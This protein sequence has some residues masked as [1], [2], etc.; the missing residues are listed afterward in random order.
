MTNVPSPSRATR[1]SRLMKSS[2]MPSPT[3]TEATPGAVARLSSTVRTNSRCSSVVFAIAGQGDARGVE[4]SRRE[5]DVGK[6]RDSCLIEIDA[7]DHEERHR[8]SGL[9]GRGE[10]LE[11]A[12]AL[13]AAGG[14]VLQRGDDGRAAE[15]QRGQRAEHDA[16]HQAEPDALQHEPGVGLEQ[17]ERRAPH[18]EQPGDHDRAAE[19]DGGREGATE[20][21]HHQ[22]LAQVVAHQAPAPRAHRGPHRQLALPHRAAHQHHAGDVQP[23]DEQHGGGQA[24]QHQPRG[25]E[26][27][28]HARPGGEVGLDAAGLVLI[29]GWITRR[30][31]RHAACTRASA[32]ATVVPS[33]SRTMA[34]THPH[35]G[36]D[37]HPRW[38]R[39]ADDATAAAR[40]GSSP[41]SDC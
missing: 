35:R 36:A 4:A 7:A 25:R 22:R 1:T 9:R 34:C 13:A 29:R 8:K 38:Q 39:A 3:L 27:R 26:L 41:R 40:A 19:E 2:G 10:A 20:Q 31:R 15:A 16:G 17:I 37:A 33:C 23:D 18:V 11:P 5:A 12:D 32:C 30:E 21:R 6:G 24:E 14:V 28:P